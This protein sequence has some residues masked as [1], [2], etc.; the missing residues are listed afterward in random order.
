MTRRNVILLCILAL[1]GAGWGVTQP[2]SKIAVSTGYRHLGLIFWQLA[3]GAIAM[4]A[5]LSFVLTTGDRRPARRPFRYD[6]GVLYEATR[7]D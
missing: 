3:P 5:D 2:L 1:M 6:H 7:L 4:A